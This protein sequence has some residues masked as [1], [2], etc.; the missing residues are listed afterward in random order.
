MFNDFGDDDNGNGNDEP[1]SQSDFPG[2]PYD[3]N[4]KPD[5]DTGEIFRDYGWST[6]GDYLSDHWGGSSDAGAQRPPAYGDIEGFIKD[7][8]DRGILDYVDF[9]TDGFEIDYTVDID[10]GN[11]GK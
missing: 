5:G 10:T 6:W 9:T 1:Y 2:F 8:Y 7:F 3:V 4:D 11:V